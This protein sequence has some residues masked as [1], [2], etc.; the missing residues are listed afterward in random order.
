MKTHPILGVVLTFA[1]AATPARGLAAN[2][3]D[4]AEMLRNSPEVGLLNNQRLKQKYPDGLPIHEHQERFYRNGDLTQ[5]PA[6]WEAPSWTDAEVAGPRKVVD[7]TRNQEV[8]IQVHPEFDDGEA[9]GPMN[10]L[11]ADAIMRKIPHYVLFNHLLAAINF[12]AKNP[13]YQNA[14]R[15]I[16]PEGVHEL[17]FPNTATFVMT[18]GN[19]TSCLCTA[20]NEI[21]KANKTNQKEFIFS[22]PLDAIFDTACDPTSDGIRK[23]LAINAIGQ[24][25]Y[26]VLA[27]GGGVGNACMHKTLSLKEIYTYAGPDL[28]AD[29]VAKNYTRDFA[30]RPCL[31]M[32]SLENNTVEILLNGQF[33]TS[34]GHGPRRIHLNFTEQKYSTGETSVP[35]EAPRTG[36]T[37]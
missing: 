29:W 11:V 26:Q 35:G 4:V 8:L 24:T 13:I 34:Y 14:H 16:G 31:G 36:V 32:N 15:Y 7:L 6:P 37:M 18:G 17:E 30:A 27:D 10:A 20:I 22:L 33:L 2:D 25:K 1:A 23:N 12:S 9:N 5:E 3:K 28:F 19:F 21:L